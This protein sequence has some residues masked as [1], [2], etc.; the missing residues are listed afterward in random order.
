M[1]DT[2][3]SSFPSAILVVDDEPSVGALI[4]AVGRMHGLAVRVASTGEEGKTL[5]EREPFGCALI[6][7]NLPGVDG[8]EVMRSAR[9]L[10]PHCAVIMITGYSSKESAIEALRLGAADYIE[11]P[12][13]DV[14]LIAQKITTAMRHGQAEYE[15]DILLERLRSFQAELEAK[16]LEVLEKQSA[17][18]M[19]N[20]LLERRVKE[21]TEDLRRSMLVLQAA[22]DS[23]RGLDLTVTKHAESIIEEAKKVQISDN[24]PAGQARA[25]FARLLR[26][27]EAHVTLI[28]QWQERSKGQPAP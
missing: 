4:Q 12:F 26:R 3:T 6:D 25:L 16:D 7:K 21:A 2:P 15:R 14:R 20:E 9:E 18:V 28:Q 8:L 1:S 19:F 24:I 5:L 10:Q 13:D 11:K 22:V 17:L 23:R 27:L